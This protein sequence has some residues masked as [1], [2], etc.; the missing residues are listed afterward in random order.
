VKAQSPHLVAMGRM[1]ALGYR[2]LG[3]TV[4]SKVGGAVIRNRLKRRFKELFR[5]RRNLLPESVDLV[6]IARRGADGL[7]Y[8]ATSRE[9]DQLARALSGRLTRSS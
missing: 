2:R 8:E 3:V 7:T 9:F 1:N 4:S 6:L 5:R